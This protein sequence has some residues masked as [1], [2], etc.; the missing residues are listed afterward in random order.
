MVEADPSVIEAGA[1]AVEAGSHPLILS[2][3]SSGRTGPVP[4]EHIAATGVKRRQYGN[5][6][7]SIRLRCHIEVELDQRTLCHYDDVVLYAKTSDF[8][9]F[10]PVT[11]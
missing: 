4:A 5:A 9:V 3:L 10:G 1:A 2:T 11:I 7:R 6:R 8:D